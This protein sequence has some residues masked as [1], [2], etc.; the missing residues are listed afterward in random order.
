MRSSLSKQLPAAKQTTP[1]KKLTPAEEALA[2]IRSAAGLDTP[3][4]PPT[5]TPEQTLAR[6]RGADSLDTIVVPTECTHGHA[7]VI[8]KGG[9][10]VCKICGVEK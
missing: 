5:E 7:I 1:A 4:P 10:H 6:I 2:R 3:D 8:Y 9:K